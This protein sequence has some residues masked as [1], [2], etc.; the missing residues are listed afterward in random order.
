M[1][2]DGRV[3]QFVWTCLIQSRNSKPPWN[4][5]AASS[6]HAVSDASRRFFHIG[7]LVSRPS[8][9]SALSTIPDDSRQRDANSQKKLT[10]AATTTDPPTQDPPSL[11]VTP[12]VIIHRSS[13]RHSSLVTDFVKHPH[14]SSGLNPGFIVESYIY[15]PG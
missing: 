6:A 3:L 5:T 7:G 11:P 13:F 15:L 8:G 9:H 2:D 12:D 14:W 4:R 10:M 1:N